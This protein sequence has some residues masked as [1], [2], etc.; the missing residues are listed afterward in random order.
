[1]ES[2]FKKFGNSAAVLIPK[3]MMSELGA[4]LGD[5]ID[6]NLKDGLI[7]IQRKPDNPRE[8]WAEDAA[9]IAALGDDRPVWPEF[10]DDPDNDWTW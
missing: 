7:V 4:E 8:G 9:R 6:I 10:H 5:A 2:A 1:M 3:P